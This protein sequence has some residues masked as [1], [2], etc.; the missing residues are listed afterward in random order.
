M[1]ADGNFKR[2]RQDSDATLLMDSGGS[3]CQGHPRWNKLCHP[4]RQHMTIG[5]ADFDTGYDVKRIVGTVIISP[6]AGFN[7]VMIGN[8]DDIQRTHS[9]DM[10]QHFTDTVKTIAGS[11]VHVN[12]GAASEILMT[13]HRYLLLSFPIING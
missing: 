3:L 6:Q 12:I 13:A 4:Q 9:R 1:R 2:M 5:A 11:G 10:A 8:G 7:R